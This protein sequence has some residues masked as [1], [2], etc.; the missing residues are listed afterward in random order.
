MRFGVHLAD[1]AVRDGDLLGDGVNL[2]T[3]LQQGADPGAVW[4]SGTLFDQIRRNSPFVFD[5]LGERRFKNLSDA[6]RVYQVRSEIGGH[7][8]QT[9]PTRVSGDKPKRPSSI[10]IMP[11]RVAGRE[12]DQRILAEGL[13]E[14]LIVEL[15]RFCRLH[16]A[17]RSASFAIA[18]STADPVK[19]GDAL[20][21]RYVLDGQVRRI[22]KTLRIALTLAETETG[23]IVWSD[24]IIRASEEIWDILDQTARSTA[25]TVVGRLE[26]ASLIALRRRAP[27]NYEA[28]ECLLRGV[29]Y[30]RLGGVTDQ[31]AREA[32]K[33]FTR[34][35]KSDPNYAAAYAW[36]VCAASWLPDFDFENALRDVR[37]AIVLDPCDAESNRILAYMEFLNGND[38][39]AR[40]LSP[41]DGDEPERRLHQGAF[42]RG[43][44]LLRRSRACAVTG[45]RRGRT[46]PPAAGLLRRG[47]R[48]RALCIGSLLRSA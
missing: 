20:R 4:V 3:R 37:K 10:A 21:V 44:D 5:D 34:A 16:V 40:A 18:D 28:F 36:R 47:A 22:D 8:L 25:A 24:K 15:G 33:W 6:V 32:I 26:D 29:D 43:H 35:I 42:R 11:F 2:T 19:V 17:S 23:A 9:A 48:R 27:E 46:R 30:H 45:Q 12:D 1:V 39:A 7:R 41:R 13:N 31:N 14:E 38:E